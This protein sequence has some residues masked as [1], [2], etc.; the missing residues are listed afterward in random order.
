MSGTIFCPDIDRFCNSGRKLCPN[1][2]SS[3]G[4][5]TDGI[6]NCRSGSAGLDCS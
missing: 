6:C 3:K 2:C 4:Y 5:C 1:W